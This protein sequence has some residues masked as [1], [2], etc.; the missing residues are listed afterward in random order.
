MIS[1]QVRA[2]VTGSLVRGDQI[3]RVNDV[4]LSDSR[5]DEAVAVLKNATGAISLALRRHRT[6]D[7]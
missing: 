3:L 7:A 2:G 5:Q 1:F 4:D 6:F